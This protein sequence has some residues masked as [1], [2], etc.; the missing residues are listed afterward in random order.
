LRSPTDDIV[1][2]PV[3]KWLY[4]NK[5]WVFSG[6]G[7]ATVTVLVGSLLLNKRRNSPGQYQ[8]SGKALVNLQA[9]RDIN[10]QSENF[11]PRDS[12]T[13]KLTTDADIINVD[14]KLIMKIKYKKLDLAVLAPVALPVRLQTEKSHIALCNYILQFAIFC[15]IVT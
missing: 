11:I 10:I 15:T 8:V 1:I 5:E 14:P 6:V 3:L 12:E 13:I 4:D 9:A 2:E 7:V